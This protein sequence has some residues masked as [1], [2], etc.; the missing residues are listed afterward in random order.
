MF[1]AGLKNIKYRADSFFT[2]PLGRQVE[3]QLKEERRVH[4]VTKSDCS[5]SASCDQYKV[6]RFNLIPS[7]CFVPASM[8][9]HS[10]AGE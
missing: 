6:A 3:D 4:T 8:S 1:D 2:V 7:Q 9:R 5:R 10:L